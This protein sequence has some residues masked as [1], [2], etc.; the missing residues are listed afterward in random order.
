MTL[1]FLNKSLDGHPKREK[2]ERSKKTWMNGIKI[3]TD[4]KPT[5]R[6][7]ARQNRMEAKKRKT[8]DA[9]TS[10]IRV[11]RCLQFFLIK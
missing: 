5:T 10:D 8:Q 7:L 6:T 1:E 11:A 2:N 3:L 9:I 4:T